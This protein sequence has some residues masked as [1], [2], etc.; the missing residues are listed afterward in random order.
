V[1]GSGEEVGLEEQRE[2]VSCFHVDLLSPLLVGVD[3]DKK[4]DREGRALEGTQEGHRCI[5]RFLLHLVKGDRDR[6]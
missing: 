6:A 4:E 5:I 2:V 1:E 3:G